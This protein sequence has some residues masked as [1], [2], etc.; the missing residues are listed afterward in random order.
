MLACPVIDETSGE[1][2]AVL[3]ILNKKD[4]AGFSKEDEKLL[5]MLAFHVSVF[6]HQL[7]S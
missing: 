1:V 3:Q 4:S 2:V 5:M 6:L 7:K